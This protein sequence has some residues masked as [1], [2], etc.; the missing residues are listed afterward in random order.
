MKDP[1]PLNLALSE[2]Y[3][4]IAYSL[5]VLGF[6]V[7]IAREFIISQLRREEPSYQWA[8]FIFVVYVAL[9]YYYR[10]G[11]GTLIHHLKG[12]GSLHAGSDTVD[13]VFVA[14]LQRYVTAAQAYSAKDSWLGV[15]SPETL[16]VTL[17]KF[18][19]GITYIAALA[20]MAI[21]RNLQVFMLA[22]IVAYGPVLIAAASLGRFFRGLAVAWLW[23]LVELCAWGVTMS[24]LLIAL[25]EAA[26]LQG[27]SAVQ[28]VADLNF[29]DEIITAGV[30]VLALVSV[31]VITSMLIRGS[32]A[33][34]LGHM[35]SRSLVAPAATAAMGFARGAAARAYRPLPAGLRS[36]MQDFANNP[37]GSMVSGARSVGSRLRPAE[38]PAERPSAQSSEQ[39]ARAARNRV[40]A[41]RENL[42]RRAGGS[43]P[44]RSKEAKAARE[45]EAQKAQT[46]KGA[47]RTAVPKAPASKEKKS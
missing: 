24:V 14:R 15:L 8:L 3:M 6:A 40:F 26:V 43:R 9:L 23:A 16:E 42:R 35:L 44:S 20:V 18:A 45:A 32:A 29:V 34:A 5:V 21:L 2:P 33:G 37:I 17:Y 13:K 11:V 27:P 10:D 47:R 41:V 46:T 1:P 12:L 28:K 4:S 25:K 31:P 36:R 7:A 39:Q 30:F 38:K 19:T 22:C